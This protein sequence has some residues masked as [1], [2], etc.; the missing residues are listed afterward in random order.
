M[1][2]N[3][4]ARKTHRPTKQNCFL[5]QSKEESPNHCD[6]IFSERWKKDEIQL[7]NN[8]NLLF[9]SS[10]CCCKNFCCSS[11]SSRRFS[12]S[13]FAA[14]SCRSL[15][16]SNFLCRSSIFF[17]TSLSCLLCSSSSS[18]FSSSKDRLSSDASRG[19]APLDEGAGLPPEL[20]LG[21]ALRLLLP[22]LLARLLPR[23][24]LLEWLEWLLLRLLAW[25]RGDS[26][27][28]PLS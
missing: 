12:F 27:P 3:C 28:F 26:S 19:D 5:Q 10:I 21:L 24:P 15:S 23:L 25:L 8:P 16:S 9:C 1:L 7:Y 17:S 14:F 20:P 2:E 22:W 18:F 11:S 13:S 6:G 4:R